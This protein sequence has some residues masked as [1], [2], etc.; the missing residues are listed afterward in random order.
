MASEPHTDA[1]DSTMDTRKV[2]KVGGSTYTV[3]I[4]KHWAT[5]QGIE[6]GTVVHLHT[7]LDDA[8]VV[9]TERHDGG[10]LN[11][12]ELAVDETRERSVGE[13]LRPAYVTGYDEIVL[14]SE[15]EFTP[16]QRRSVVKTV[17][18]LMGM[19]IV[20]ETTDEVVV[21]NLINAAEVSVL[22]SVLQLRSIALSMNE[23]AIDALLTGDAGK[24]ARV[25]ERD[26]EVDRLYEMVHRHFNRSL[27]SLAEVDQL[28]VGRNR[29]FVL[30]RTARQL[31]RV[32]DHAERIATT[33]DRLGGTPS[34]EMAAE[35]D[36]AAAEARH[37]VEAAT[38]VVLGDGDVQRAYA[39]LDRRDDVLATVER[40]D[41]TLFETSGADE[42]LLTRA[43][44]S[45]GR[46][47][48]YGGNV[49]ET[50]IRA[51]ARDGRL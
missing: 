2:Q 40:V 10:D 3:S 51:A 38:S 27:T 42:Y 50:A 11:R 31:E 47:A 4:P 20:T 19:E 34:E 7:H 26:D 44:D 13:L 49:A 45:I 48:E 22:Q 16:E 18:D 30:Y 36:A 32:A 28:G 43:V 15:E 33:A 35:I 23:T 8:L 17:R 39:A 37:V 21:Q 6:A 1:S 24:I 14:R 41:Q 46:T 5:E 29:L 12:I 9:K 25:V